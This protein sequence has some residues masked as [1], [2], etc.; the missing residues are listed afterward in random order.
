[1]SFVIE[2]GDTKYRLEQNRMSTLSKQPKKRKKKEKEKEKEKRSSFIARP[3]WDPQRL[4]EKKEAKTES[5]CLEI[6]YL[7]IKLTAFLL[8]LL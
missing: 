6:T 1:M 4:G 8:K 3:M 2:T 7:S 5:V